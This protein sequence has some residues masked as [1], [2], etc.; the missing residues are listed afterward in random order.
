MLAVEMESFSG[1]INV[2]VE[3]T[4]ARSALYIAVAELTVESSLC[5]PVIML[6][7][8]TR[9]CSDPLVYYMHRVCIVHRRI[10]KLAAPYSSDEIKNCRFRLQNGYMG[11]S[12]VRGEALSRSSRRPEVC[13][14][15]R[16]MGNLA[17]DTGTVTQ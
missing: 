9:R 11:Q 4:L 14:L 10:S 3:T 17:I 6:L 13:V 5:R 2:S 12:N 7:W 15:S 16:A 1:H 8:Y